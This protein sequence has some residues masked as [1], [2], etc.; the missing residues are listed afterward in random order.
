MPNAPPPNLEIKYNQGSIAQ[1]T[2]DEIPCGSRGA[3]SFHYTYAVLVDDV[4][5]YSGL[6]LD[7]SVTVFDLP[8]GRVEFRVAVTTDVGTGPFSEIDPFN[9]VA[10]PGN[11]LLFVLYHCL[12]YFWNI[13]NRCINI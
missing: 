7:T 6:T 13:N 1:F 4:E 9:N 11:Y 2:W 5:H 10:L 3:K 8:Y 12:F